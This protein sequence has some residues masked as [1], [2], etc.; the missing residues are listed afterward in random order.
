[1]TKLPRMTYAEWRASKADYA[2]VVLWGDEHDEQISAD[3]I[4]EAIEVRI[5]EVL[6]NEDD[7]AETV[8]VWGYARMEVKV[9]VD[10]LLESVIEPLD[11]ELGD[12]DGDYTEPTAA[13][14]EAAKAFAKVVEKEY[15]QWACESVVAVEVNVAAWQTAQK[16]QAR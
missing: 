4:D 10:R 5:D 13:M 15:V 12:P 11:E 9:D 16:E 7:A 2:N 14:L 3:D 8:T 1:M 6:T